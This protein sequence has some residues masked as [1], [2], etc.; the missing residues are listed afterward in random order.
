MSDA[1]EK[2]D[3]IYRGKPGVMP[4]NASRVLVENHHLLPASGD[5]LELACGLA[6][7]AVL[8]AQH[9]LRTQSWDISAV[10]AERVAEYA[11]A[12][13]LPL[14]AEARDLMR[15]PPVPATCDVIVVAH[16]LER[17]LFPYILA[18]LRP[19]GLLFYQT[20]TRA[21]ISDAGPSN[22]EFRLA[23]G[24]LLALCAKLEVLVYREEGLIGDL[25]KG[26]R[27]EAMIVARR[28]G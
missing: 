19:G 3:A 4:G 12:H 28:P 2:W 9:G 25:E 15:N 21:R 11:R 24:E 10:A 14:T 27:D 20:F 23:S 16:F 6:G 13:G 18:A 17:D 26:L 8:L 7:N 1:R 5:A 22:P